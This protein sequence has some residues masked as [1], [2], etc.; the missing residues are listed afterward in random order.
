MRTA[1]GACSANGARSTAASQVDQ[2]DVAQDGA[3]ASSSRGGT[4]ASIARGGAGA[5][6]AV[7]DPQ[8]RQAT[9]N[10][11]SGRRRRG[12]PNIRARSEAGL[13]RAVNRLFQMPAMILF[14]HG[15]TLTLAVINRR[16]HKR[17]D[18]L[19]GGVQ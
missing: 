11:A 2:L 12:L 9:S 5:G 8:D 7:L 15:D 13:T 10:E 14:R 3:V 16:L 19:P 6:D 18:P 4:A 17:D 1:H